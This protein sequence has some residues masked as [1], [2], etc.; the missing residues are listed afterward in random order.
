MAEWL[1]RGL[2][3][4]VLGGSLY[5]C[6]S[7][8]DAPVPLEVVP[9]TGKSAWGDDAR[10]LNGPVHVRSARGDEGPR[11]LVASG[12]GLGEQAYSRGDPVRVMQF[13]CAPGLAAVYET[14]GQPLVRADQ[15]GLKTIPVRWRVNGGVWHDSWASAKFPGRGPAQDALWLDIKPWGPALLEQEAVVDLVLP[16]VPGGPVELEV[17]GDGVMEAYYGALDRCGYDPE[18]S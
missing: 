11:L 4:I 17:H 2:G 13:V 3:L 14:P 6:A 9:E 1:A 18:R 10:Y 16:D 15:V 12:G 8:L 7:F 5:A